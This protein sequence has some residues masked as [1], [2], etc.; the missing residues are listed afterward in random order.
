MKKRRILKKAYNRAIE[1]LKLER[2]RLI[3]VQKE[4][5]EKLRQVQIMHER[6]V[7]AL[8]KD[9]DTLQARVRELEHYKTSLDMPDAGFRP[10][11]A[12]Q[13]IMIDPRFEGIMPY[14]RFTVKTQS[15]PSRINLGCPQYVRFRLEVDTS[16]PPLEVNQI[17]ILN[18][19]FRSL[20]D[21]I[22]K[23]TNNIQKGNN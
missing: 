15:E 17:R 7:T 20:T 13:D 18:D 11:V 2:K 23:K 8:K 12:C 3:E 5:S 22:Y 16:N 6:A 4:E 14:I 19:A 1:K 10:E 9:R 21:F